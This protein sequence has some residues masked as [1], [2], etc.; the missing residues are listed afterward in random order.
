MHHRLTSPQREQK[1]SFP[2]FAEID[3]SHPLKQAVPGGYVEYQARTRHGGR[4]IYFNFDLAKEMGLVPADTADEVTKDLEKAILDAFAIQ[5]INEYD[6]LHKVQFPPEDIRPNKYMATRYLQL[7]HPDKKGT[8]SGDGRSIWN[9]TIRHKGVAWDVSS[10]GTGATCLSPATAIEGRFF[11]TGTT[12]ASYGCGLS[13]VSEGIGAALM[14]G[15]F[16]KNG[17]ATER[18]LC[19]IEFRSGQSITVRAARNLLRP[20]H[21]F[22]HLKQ[23]NYDRL[24]GAVDYYIDRQVQNGDLKKQSTQEKTYKEMGRQ[25]AVDF[26]RA[27]ARFEADYI[28][29]WMDWDGDNV[30]MNG[31]IIDYGSVRQFGLYHHEYRYDDVQRF[32]TTIPQ[33]KS[34]ARETVQRFAQLVDYLITKT[35]SSKDRFKNDA[36]LQ[37][38]DREFEEQLLRML[39][40]K[41]GFN[42]TQ[43]EHL[44]R[45]EMGLV[46][47]FKKIHSYFEK[48]QSSRGTYVVGDGVTC[49]A[50][51]CMRDL[52][53]ELPIHFLRNKNMPS[54][55][56][57]MSMMASSYAKKKDKTVTPKRK[58]RIELFER[59][60]LRLVNK[61]AAANKVAKESVFSEIVMRSSVINMADRITGDAIIT[62]TGEL[63]KTRRQFKPN[64]LIQIM[65]HFVDC[66][67]REPSATV[68]THLPDVLMPTKPVKVLQRMLNIVHELREGI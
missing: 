24:K 23:S 29:V 10:C 48:A 40:H 1:S 16:H 68:S 2:R 56:E 11:K 46:K 38:F 37:I 6:I 65:E 31:G 9:G 44:M 54:A 67:R 59:L 14:S 42:K 27:A 28:F 55:N 32:S 19:V 53:R 4:V 7:Q 45:N 13:Q 34:K 61:V 52:L 39:L 64:E 63:V 51:Y 49:D 5:I 58:K 8:T 22:H 15:I 3:G 60:Y 30:L 57:F 35:K 20:S 66:Q 36:L 12:I 47:K 25:I 41:V 33:Q 50:I 17:I 18:T 43:R 26:A 62:V 21:F